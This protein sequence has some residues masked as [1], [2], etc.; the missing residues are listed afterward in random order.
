M[1]VLVLVATIVLIVSE[2]LPLIDCTSVNGI[3]HGLAL[4]ITKI[5]TRF[6]HYTPLTPLSTPPARH[7]AVSGN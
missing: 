4:V 1:E 6:E 2:V 3:V 7:L 5:S